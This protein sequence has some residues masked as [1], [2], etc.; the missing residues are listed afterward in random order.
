MQKVLLKIL[1]KLLWMGCSSLRTADA[2]YVTGLPWAMSMS[3]SSNHMLVKL[4]F[5]DGLW[6]RSAEAR[7]MAARDN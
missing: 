4:L 6:A 1:E 5:N 3:V 7:V 2:C